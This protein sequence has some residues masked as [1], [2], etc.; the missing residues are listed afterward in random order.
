MANSFKSLEISQWQQFENIKIDFHERLTVLT[1]ANAS[2]KTTILNLLAKHHDW[3][4]QSCAVPRKTKD[5]GIFKFFTRLFSGRDL[6]SENKIGQITYSNGKSAQLLIPNA[7]REQVGWVQSRLHWDETHHLRFIFGGLRFTPPTLQL[8]PPTT[9][10]N[11]SP[12]ALF[13]HYVP[14]SR[15]KP[16]SQQDS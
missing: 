13:P 12:P 6:S 5:S 3:Q 16:L 7:D 1:G 9:I 15:D 8:S 4:M 11:P 10:Q 2:G 14:N